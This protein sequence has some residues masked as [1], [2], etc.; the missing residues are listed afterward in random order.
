MAF[1]VRVC[2]RGAAAV[3]LSLFLRLFVVIIFSCHLGHSI[4]IFLQFKPH[5]LLI[6]KESLLIGCEW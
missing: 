1:F 5:R 3:Q 6:K 2:S 4:E